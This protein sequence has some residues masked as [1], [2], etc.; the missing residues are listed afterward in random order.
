MRKCKNLLC[1]KSIDKPSKKIF[2]SVPCRREYHRVHKE[3]TCARSSCE[4]TFTVTNSR[5]KFCSVECRKKGVEI[6]GEVIYVPP[7]QNKY[8]HDYS[9]VFSYPCGIYNMV[10]GKLR[11]SGAKFEICN[12]LYCTNNICSYWFQLFQIPIK[13]EMI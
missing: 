10:Y 8:N 3:K 13:R 7:V 4:N 2:C 6:S 11:S 1:E 9:F 5:R 12:V